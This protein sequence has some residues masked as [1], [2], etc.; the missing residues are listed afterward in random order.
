M[1]FYN[2]KIKEQIKILSKFFLGVENPT[3]YLNHLKRKVDKSFFSKKYNT[4]EFIEFL[5][6]LGVSSGDTIFLSSTWSEFYNYKGKA[7]EL[8]RAII[9]LL[10]DQGNLAMPCN[11]SLYDEDCHFDELTTPT[12][13]GLLSE[14][15]RRYPNVRRSIH[16][17]SSVCVLG[18]KAEYYT[19]NHEKSL[20]S[21]DKHSPH[22]K[23]YKDIDYSNNICFS[24]KLI[25]FFT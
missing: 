7:T 9:K 18:V 3:K 25:Y 14:V 1:I 16:I 17:N 23:L 12:S 22:F 6:A 13:A 4:Q 5:E 20:M 21:W 8:I 15:F 19:D 11:S 24:A 2:S 10:G